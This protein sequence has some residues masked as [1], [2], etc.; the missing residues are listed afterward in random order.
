MTQASDPIQAPVGTPVDTLML[1][2]Q[3]E[4]RAWG[5]GREGVV[6]VLG[7]CAGRIGTA[8]L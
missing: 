5:E 3:V 2:H 4:R 1:V 8:P 6:L 7:T